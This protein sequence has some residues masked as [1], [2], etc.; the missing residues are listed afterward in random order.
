MLSL[1]RA[2]AAA[3]AAAS[4]RLYFALLSA[5]DGRT[6]GGRTSAAEFS[7]SS[8]PRVADS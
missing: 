2:L 8:T 4:S 1:S 6:D 5:K 3:A 7:T